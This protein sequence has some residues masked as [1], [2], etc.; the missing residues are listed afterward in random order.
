M[1]PVSTRSIQRT[2]LQTAAAIHPTT[3]LPSVL[4]FLPSDE[5]GYRHD[6]RIR[7][8]RIR[9]NTQMTQC[10]PKLL[11]ILRIRVVVK[12]AILKFA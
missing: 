8:L 6:L 4:H 11:N 9:K 10:E 2:F 12:H 1:H 7:I 5:F 3:I